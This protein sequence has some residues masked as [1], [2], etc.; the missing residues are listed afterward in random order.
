MSWR[1]PKGTGIGNQPANTSYDLKDHQE[2]VAA[3][4]K[5]L[6]RWGF[7]A[8]FPATEKV[9]TSLGKKCYD[10]W[11]NYM[12]NARI[13]DELDF[14]AISGWES[15]AIEN[16]S[17]IVDNLRNFKSDPTP[18][19]DTLLPVRPVAKQRSMCTALGEAAT[20]DLYL[21]NDT[22][23]AATGTL[24][25]TVVSP[26]GK[27]IKLDEF[28]VPGWKRDQFS[29]MVKEGFITPRLTEEGMYKFKFAISSAPLS[30]QTKEIWVTESDYSETVCRVGR[31]VAVS[32]ISS[33]LR[34][35]L[36]SISGRGCFNIVDFKAGEKYDVIVSA[37]VTATAATTQ[38]AGDT[39]GLEAQ[40]SGAAVRPAVQVGVLAEGILEAVKAGTPLLAIPQTDALSDGVAK[41]LA[42]VGAFTYSGN[43]GD[44]RA[45]WMG[46]WYLVRKHPLYSGMPVDQAMG[47]HYQ[48]KGSA[49]NGLV[50]DG[51]NVEIVAAY[52]RDH[53][54]VIGAG[55]FTAK[56]GEG[57]VVYHRVPEMQPVMQ[58]RF[59]A[60]AI[61]WLVR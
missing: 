57:K 21:L 15:T 36:L 38:N 33:A 47:I 42:A 12:E 35:Q 52:S 6:D 23:K 49:A 34:K 50:V 25:F 43:V 48:A 60:N 3:Y 14:C 1:T 59:L 20:F 7:R 32:G 54:R 40:P 39:T 58:Q 27:L 56:L 22:D 37:G 24:S 29:Y 55:T 8:A 53:S 26:S 2:I 31:T 61:Q 45:P 9:W 5:F 11:Q 28:S 44:V 30:T 17:G 16:H 13:S 46:N 10:T 51:P 4:D 41:Q 19:R 18:I